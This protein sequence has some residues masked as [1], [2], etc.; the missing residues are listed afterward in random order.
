MTVFIAFSGIWWP[1]GHAQ[2]LAADISGPPFLTGYWQAMPELSGM[3]ISVDK[4]RETTGESSR[5]RAGI[6]IACEYSLY[7]GDR[8]GEYINNGDLTVL[9]DKTVIE[10]RYRL[11][12]F[13]QYRLPDILSQDMDVY[14][15]GK[16]R[17]IFDKGKNIIVVM[18]EDEPGVFQLSGYRVSGL[19]VGDLTYLGMYREQAPEQ[20]KMLLADADKVYVVDLSTM[21]QE[22]SYDLYGCRAVGVNFGVWRIEGDAK[23]GVWLVPRDNNGLYYMSLPSGEISRVSDWRGVASDGEVIKLVTGWSGRMIGGFGV[24]MLV[25]EKGGYVLYDG[26]FGRRTDS[27]LGQ[28]FGE[29][30]DIYWSM[31]YGVTHRAGIFLVERNGSYL[32]EKTVE[33]DAIY[34]PQ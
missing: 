16:R 22:Q 7:S 14:W 30:K 33:A 17:I 15:A 1:T 4:T 21:S 32:T 12:R 10:N 11:Q 20:D 34:K 24:V 28:P 25:K 13:C 19:A 2:N 31:I 3:K 23:F 8:Y 5:T 26:G 29:V 27:Y 9:E 18:K 6:A